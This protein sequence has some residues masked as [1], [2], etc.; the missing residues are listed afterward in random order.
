MRKPDEKTADA[1]PMRINK[2]LA[3]EG[4]ATRRGAD[5]LVAR[6]KVLINGRVA[7]LNNTTNV[8]RCKKI[9]ILRR[10]RNSFVATGRLP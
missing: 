5:E 8:T 7:Q 1:Y 4:I 9:A 3:H 6:G 2:Y 10:V